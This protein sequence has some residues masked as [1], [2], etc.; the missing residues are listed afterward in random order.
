M[1]AMTHPRRRERQ[2][3]NRRAPWQAIISAALL[4]AATTAVAE[5]KSLDDLLGTIIKEQ[6]AARE[7]DAEREKKF[8]E[9]RDQQA[10]LLEEARAKLAAEQARAEQLKATFAANESTLANKIASSDEDSGE[11][12]DFDAVV[13]QLATDLKGMLDASLVSAQLPDR[14]KFVDDLA[15]R[16]DKPTMDDVQQLWQTVLQETIESGKVA[17]FKANVISTQGKDEPRTVTRLGVFGA[18]SNGDFL[19]YA[20]EVHQLV[21]QARQPAG[22]YRRM[23]KELENAKE[24]ITTVAFDPTR[25]S[26]LA[27]LSQEPTLWE[28]IKQAE[29]V[30]FVTLGLGAIAIFIALWRY[31]ALTSTARAV[32]R[33]RRH[34]EP[35]ERNPLGR[36]MKAFSDNKIVDA[37]TLERKL[38][39]AIL[40]ELP[41]IQRGLGALMVI[42]EAAPLLGLLGTVSGMVAT[43][44]AL[45][46]FGAGDAKVVAGGI[47]EALVATIIGLCVAI[48]TLVVHSFLKSKSDAIVQVLDEQAAGMVARLAEAHLRARQ[49][50]AAAAQAVKA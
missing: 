45:S 25:G 40:R 37:E 27:I 39:D 33:Q 5:P 24:G 35:D 41:P 31:F 10:A 15:K 30:G 19:R 8:A 9:A 29:L 32:A 49:K 34:A 38:D 18:T 22:V 20:P 47:S 42:A 43:F 6:Q 48:P 13:R 36:V 12:R 50:T 17:Q 1:I 21:E 16:E 14:L 44:Q 7:R 11:L 28:R 26:M 46:M 3:A 4:L 2:L 23:A